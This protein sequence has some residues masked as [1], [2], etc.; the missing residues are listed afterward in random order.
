MF[1]F[2]LFFIIWLIDLPILED[3]PYVKIWIFRP[4]LLKIFI[5][6]KKLR[7][8]IERRQYLFEKSY[9]QKVGCYEFLLMTRLLWTINFTDTHKKF[10]FY[11][12]IFLT[13]LYGRW[14]NIFFMLVTALMPVFFYYFFLLADYY[15]VL[16]EILEYIKVRLG[17]S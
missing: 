9:E 2:L 5:P 1:D 4:Y 16:E 10:L 17:N 12:S 13:L 7:A 14:T 3:Y 6:D 11:C 8:R 15:E